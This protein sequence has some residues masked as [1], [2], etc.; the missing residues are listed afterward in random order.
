MKSIFR[1][2]IL[3]F[4]AYVMLTSL[5]ALLRTELLGMMSVQISMR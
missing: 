2:L 5:I 4:I 3:F 1:F